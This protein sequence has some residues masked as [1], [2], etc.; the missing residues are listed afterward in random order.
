MTQTY[1][2]KLIEVSIP[3]EAINAASVREKSIRHGHPSTLHLWWARRPLAACRAVLFAQLVD[4]PSSLP[5]QFPTS[6]EQEAE[7]E[8][9]FEIIEDLVKWENSTNEEVLERARAEIMRSCG[10]ELPPIYD[11][12][13]GGGSIPLEAQ[14]LGLPAYGSD[15]NPVAVMI[16]KA[17]IEIPPKFKDMEPIHP[18]G[19]ERAFYRNAE[20][21][22]E[23][24]KHYGVWMREK[25]FERIGHLYPKVDMPEEYGGGKATV[26]AWIWARTVPSPDPAFA[27]V[28][29]PLISSYLLSSTKGKEA[30]IEPSID[31]AAK[32]ISYNIRKGDTKSELDVIKL[33]TTAGKRQ[34]FRCIMSE[35]AI[36]YEYIRKAGRSGKMGQKLIAV[37]AEGNNGRAFVEPTNLQEDTAL[38]A[39]P[40]WKPET[41]LS[42][43][44]RDLPTQNYGL[45]TFGD[46]FTSRQLVALNTFSDLVHEA[47][48]QIEHDAL[49]AEFDSDLTTLRDG[50]IGAKAYAE[51]VSL[52]SSFAITKMADR[53][54]S[55]CSWDSSRS[56][57]RNTFGRQAAS[58][59]WDFAECNFL[60]DSTGNFGGAIDWISKAICGFQPRNSGTVRQQDA[61]QVS[62]PAGSVISTDPPYYDNIGYADL[63]DFFYVWLRRLNRQ[64]F[65]ELTAVLAAPKA[66]ELVAM[67]YRH[68][69]K[70]NAEAFFLSGMTQAIS[71]LSSQSAQDYPATI[72]YAFKQSEIA[73][74]GISS[75]GWAA[76]LQAVIEAGYA[77]VGTW[78]LRTE[79]T[80]R[81]IA[82][83][84]NALANSIVLV[85]RKR[86]DTAAIITRAEFLREL[87]RELPPAIKDIQTANLAPADIPQSTIGPG[88]GVFSRYKEVLEAD[89]NPMTVKTALQLINAEL[90]EYLGGIQG[91]FDDDT[92]FAITWF[93]QNGLKAGDYGTANN[94]ATARGISVDS[95]KHAGIIE[96]Q[97]GEVRILKRAELDSKWEPQAVTHN[98]TVWECLQYL[99]RQH[100]EA[101]VSYETALLLRK[102]EGKAG[103]V[104]DLAYCLYNICTN[105]KRPDAKEANA[106]NALISDWSHLTREAAEVQDIRGTGQINMDF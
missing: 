101:G 67:P 24:V 31:K 15:L 25:A 4:D 58:M 38:S 30:W 45:T 73:K 63:S 16:G 76:F 79:M 12:F 21:L 9:L 47:R 57:L 37:V 23:D 32:T 52:Y 22:A 59:I 55:I 56:S 6:E 88:M 96:S 71:N 106:Y 103:A 50:G 81:I 97:A 14:R 40:K 46:L 74:E 19:K 42:D 69:G 70:T 10:G 61:Q 26:I 93:E 27:D 11:P 3:L 95:V 65:P 75:T 83:G 35:A 5:E 90:D 36:P 29:V 13:S 54:S 89:D 2:K 60:S 51:A 92:R 87:K 62:L 77:V 33:G 86:E 68:G 7:R 99:V 49:S 85:C 17:M 18:G 78:P 72:Y 8:R 94:I 1:K 82:S 102:I 91:E 34:A 64:V 41:Q 100:E 20:G 53:G 104:K 80:N 39:R 66:E 98:L 43:N 48:E 84:T 105:N 28:Q 44:R